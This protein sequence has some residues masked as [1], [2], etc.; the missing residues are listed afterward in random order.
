MSY[1]DPAKTAAVLDGL[2][3]RKAQQIAAMEEWARFRAEADQMARARLRATGMLSEADAIWGDKP[4]MPEPVSRGDS[5]AF[6][7]HLADIASGKR[8]VIQ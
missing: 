6:L 5:A 7:D 2:N 3:A 8:Q 1:V 4:P